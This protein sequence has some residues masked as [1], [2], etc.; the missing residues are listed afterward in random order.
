MLEGPSPRVKDIKTQFEVD[1][2]TILYSGN[3]DP[4]QASF[5][6]AYG[7]SKDE[8]TF[9]DGS[10]FKVQPRWSAALVREEQSWKIANF[11]YSVNVF[12]NPV[13]DKMKSTNVIVAGVT[14]VFGLFFGFLYGRR[15]KR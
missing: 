6:V 3:G 1:D 5:G 12:K 7:H 2:L 8:Y 11:H 15:Q 9:A 14:L 4:R 13:V 10:K